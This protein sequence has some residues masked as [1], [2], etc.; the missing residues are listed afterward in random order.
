MDTKE[1]EEEEEDEDIASAG[2]GRTAGEPMRSSETDRGRM[3]GGSREEGEE[4]S[5][6]E[7]YN[8]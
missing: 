7:G 2:R 5:R 8:R 1:R 3:G 4:R 6:R